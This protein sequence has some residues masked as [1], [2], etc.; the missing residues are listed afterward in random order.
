MDIC[1]SLVSGI[2]AIYC[3]EVIYTSY[4]DKKVE[5]NGRNNNNSKK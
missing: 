4:R 5:K 1:L 3:I 2:L